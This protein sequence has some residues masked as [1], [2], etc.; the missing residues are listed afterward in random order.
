M[1]QRFPIEDFKWVKNITQFSKDFTKNYN[2]DSD[3]RYFLEGNI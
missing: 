3:E 1:S 2:E